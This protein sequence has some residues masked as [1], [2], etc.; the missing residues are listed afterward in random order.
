MHQM[1]KRTLKALSFTTLILL[2]P[3][4]LADENPENLIKEG[5]FFGEI[6]YRYENVEQ[7][8]ALNDAE[9]YTVRTNLGFKTGQLNGFSGL[10]EGQL[11]QNL[12]DEEFN[13]LDNGQTA[14]STVADPD[15]AQIN[16]SWV[17]YAG[18]PD[19]VVRVGRQF[20]NLDNQRFVGTV[21]WRQN[22]QTFDALTITNSSVDSLNVQYAYIDTVN[23]IFEGSS[24]PDDLESETHLANVSYQFSDLLTATVYGYWMDFD[25]IAGFTAAS[26]NQSNETYG[27]RLSGKTPIDE[28]WM[29]AYEAEAAMQE[30]HGNSTLNYDENYYHIAPK[31]SGYGFT[32]GAGYEVLEGDGTNAFRTPLATLH[33]FNGWADVFLTTPANGLE[34]AYLTASY[35]FSDT[36]TLA[37]G[38]KFIAAYHDFEGE[39][40]GDYGDELDL[41][42]AKTFDLPDAGQPFKKINIT[43]KYA[44]YDAD[45]APYVDTEKFWLQLG[46]KF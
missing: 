31:V 43:L 46:V 5:H 12:G 39:E 21:G 34:D 2:S 26:A 44:D 18:L 20:I 28:N 19:T 8:N 16:R 45:D 25:N 22:D 11:V 35:Q 38:L 14:Y 9:A 13:S 3:S 15:T 29:F 42:L 33:K 36:G 7:N 4:A 24:P 37:D 40:S 1:N 17:Q 23:R 32:L 10:I 30:D 41:S 27:I 6:R